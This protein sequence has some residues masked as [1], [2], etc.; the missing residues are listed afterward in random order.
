M[1]QT[2]N[3][4]SLPCP[5]PVPVPV[6]R[7]GLGVP[8]PVVGLSV[9]ASSRWRYGLVGYLLST[10]STIYY[11]HI[12]LSP[13]QGLRLY[14]RALYNS[15]MRHCGVSP[16]GVWGLCPL[17]FLCRALLHSFQS[18]VSCQTSPASPYLAGLPATNICSAMPA[19]ASSFTSSRP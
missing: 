17:R 10:I 14:L 13:V 2:A 11:G 4:A 1:A 12:V 7:D 6:R 3:R 15:R 5:V 18:C 8:G 16:R 9:V 19:L